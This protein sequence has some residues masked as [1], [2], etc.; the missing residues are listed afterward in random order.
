MRYMRVLYAWYTLIYVAV[1]RCAFQA[2]LGSK[3]LLNMLI[4]VLEDR[5]FSAVYLIQP[6]KFHARY[7]CIKYAF[8]VLF[9]HASVYYMCVP[10]LRDITPVTC[11]SVYETRVKRLMRAFSACLANVLAN[12]WDVT[13][14]YS[15]LFTVLRFFIRPA[16]AAHAPVTR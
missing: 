13:Q 11:P 7:M 1:C 5:R 12:G 10:I 6:N 15:K 2:C 8:G 14:T 9:M 16:G 3:E 4:F